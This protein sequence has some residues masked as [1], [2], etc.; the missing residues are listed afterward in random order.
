[1]VWNVGIKFIWTH[2]APPPTVFGWSVIPFP[3]RVEDYAHS[4]PR[5]SDLPR[6]LV[7]IT[8]IPKSAFL[9]RWWPLSC[10]R[11]PRNNYSGE[12]WGADQK[13]THRGVFTKHILW[14]TDDVAAKD[15]PETHPEP[16]T[17]VF[18]RF[19]EKD[20]ISHIA[21]WPTSLRDSMD[22]FSRYVFF[23]FVKG[24]IKP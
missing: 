6:A 1:M 8:K 20:Q 14:S 9:T 24:E 7:W 23:W 17:V 19:R 15:L 12:F 21:S 4:R 18:T 10:V 16:F 5:F 2:S 13:S 11:R 22:S 3:T